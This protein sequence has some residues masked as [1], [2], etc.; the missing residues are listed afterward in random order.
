[1]RIR[2]AIFPI[3]WL[4]GVAGYA[5]NVVDWP[6]SI[7]SKKDAV[8]SARLSGNRAAYTASLAELRKASPGLAALE[9]LDHPDWSPGARQTASTLLGIALRDPNSAEQ[10]QFAQLEILL[11]GSPQQKA[12]AIELLQVLARNDDPEAIGMLAELDAVFSTDEKERFR[13]PQQLTTSAVAGGA[14]KFLKSNPIVA[15]SRYQIRDIAAVEERLLTREAARR[16]PASMVR[17][18]DRLILQGGSGESYVRAISLYQQAM[19]RGSVNAQVRLGV[20]LRDL[21]PPYHNM[22]KSLRLLKAA[23]DQGSVSA[24]YELGETY[25]TGRGVKRDT[26]TAVRFYEQAVRGGSAGAIYRIGDMYMRGDGLPENPALA[27]DWFRRGVK[28]GNKGCLR[29]LGLAYL[30]GKGAE[31]NIEEG[32]RLIEQAANGGDVSSMARLASMYRLG[33]NVDRDFAKSGEWALKAVAAGDKNVRIL[34]M[35]AATLAQSGGSVNLSRAAGLLRLAMQGGSSDARRQLANLLLSTG[36]SRN[37][38]EAILL[39]QDGARRGDPRSLAALGSLYATGNGVEVDAGRSLLYYTVA[40][41]RGSGEGLRGLAI[42]YAA[43]FGVPRDTKRAVEYFEIAS[44]QGDRAAM[45]SL[46]NCWLEA[47]TGMRDVGKATQLFVTAAS[48][49]DSESDFQLG[50]LM[51]NGAIPGGQGAAVE[52]LKAAAQQDHV[53]AEKLLKRLGVPFEAPPAP[54]P[55]VE[56]AI[57]AES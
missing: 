10:A 14:L 9:L 3:V 20:V 21:P 17:L 5:A 55:E 35:A 38:K 50:T 15:I 49:G 54:F 33:Q 16:E 48:L 6:W 26:L 4:A 22:P 46:A 51:L 56:Q 34:G 12:K 42:A 52:K 13:I 25:R 1:M 40:A 11:K 2:R 45:R 18:A 47:C 23:S 27:V 19:D 36:G 7:D 30:E 28:A 39:L 29:A 53:A 31:Q 37:E 43:G 32:R 24:A 57:E 41:Q 8:S 44:A